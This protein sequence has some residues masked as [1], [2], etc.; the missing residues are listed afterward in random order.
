M[1][2]LPPVSPT[3]VAED[4]PLEMGNDDQMQV[5]EADPGPV[6]PNLDILLLALY[7]HSVALPAYLFH[8]YTV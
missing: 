7:A 3:Q 5:V 8:L 1:G 6:M 2:R 4:D